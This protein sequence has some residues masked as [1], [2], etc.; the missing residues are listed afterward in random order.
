MFLLPC[1]A[2]HTFGRVLFVNGGNKFRHYQQNRVLG[3]ESRDEKPDNDENNLPSRDPVWPTKTTTTT[4]RMSHHWRQWL[5]WSLRLW[6]LFLRWNSGT[7]LFWIHFACTCP[8]RSFGCPL[9]MV[10]IRSYWFTQANEDVEH[11][12]APTMSAINN[13]V[14]PR[15]LTSGCIPQIRYIWNE[16]ILHF[17]IVSRMTWLD[18]VLSVFLEFFFFNG[19]IN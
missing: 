10:S 8:F 14:E 18:Y 4:R 12:L 11:F 9:G 6:C 1:F 15:A 3:E 17:S 5:K 13:W 7:Y 2:S 16:L 19:P